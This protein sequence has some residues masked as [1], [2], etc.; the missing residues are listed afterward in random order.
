[1]TDVGDGCTNNSVAFAPLNNFIG[2]VKEQSFSEW[3]ANKPGE[4]NSFA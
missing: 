2:C 3:D 1:M 4:I